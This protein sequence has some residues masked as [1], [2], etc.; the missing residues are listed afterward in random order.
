M[1]LLPSGRIQWENSA[2]AA[3]LFETLRAEGEELHSTEL[4]D[5]LSQKVFRLG[6]F[7][8]LNNQPVDPLT[9]LN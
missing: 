8:C 4:K 1:G 6:S 2:G 5:F 7:Y 3:G 9:Q